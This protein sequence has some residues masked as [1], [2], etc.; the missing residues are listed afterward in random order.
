MLILKQN[1]ASGVPTPAAGKYT[2]YVNEIGVLSIKNS[3]GANTA[4]PTVPA[5]D[6]RILYND[7]DLIGSSANF[8][9]SKISN[10][11]TVTGNQVVTGNL[12]VGGNILLSGNITIGDQTLD[13]VTVVADFTSNLIPNAS[14][15]YDI[16][17]DAKRWNNIFAETFDT[18]GIKIKDNVVRTF[19][20]NADLELDAAGTGQVS[21]IGSL[22]VN[23]T[24][25]TNTDISNWNTAYGWGDHGIE[26]YI[27]LNDL[28]IGPND[29]ASGGG[30]IAYNF[31]TG[32]FTYTPPNL[33]SYLTAE[34][35]TL[36]SVTARGSTTSNSITVGELSVDSIN[37]SNNKIQTIVSNADLELDAAGTGQVSIIGSLKVNGTSFTNT[38]ISNW[39][40]AYGWGDH[41]IVG[42]LTAES[43]TLDSVTARGSTTSN[44]ITIGELS[45]DSIN[46]SN[47]V[48]RTTDTNA[49]LELDAAGTGQVS[50]IGNLKVNG[51]SFTNT[52]ISNWN[53]AYGWGD[54]AIAGYQS[55][56]LPF[57]GDVRGSVFGDDSS[58]LV[59]GVNSR[60]QGPV[61]LLTSPPT[62]SLG[63]TG[64]VT[65]LIAADAT[66]IYY[67]I[68]NYDGVSDIWVK[69]PWTTTGSWS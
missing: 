25:F 58:T 67:C 5:G 12:D 33:S 60:L 28:S 49:D 64:D 52:D 62:T 47:N 38:D 51:T 19:N 65:G 66:N 35:D 32:V 43:D 8:T 9:F 13:S 46:I 34:S 22:K 63:S 30:G 61:V 57:V 26:N 11:L 59:D 50:V 39:N 69:T 44:S 2:V 41:A 54:H 31:S 6:T 1:I 55:S 68:G 7:N 27:R 21:V 17:S 4:F 42:Y 14:D 29:P 53:T 45:V 56:S 18:G 3:A 37:I 16:G 15:T 48:I 24:S 23:G 40:T 20:S 10:T 36:D